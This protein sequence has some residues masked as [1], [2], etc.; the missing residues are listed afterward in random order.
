MDTFVTF[1]NLICNMRIDSKN[2][3]ARS[4]ENTRGDIT[5]IAEIQ[6]RKA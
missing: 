1:G 3:A 4:C 6:L 5:E 2:R